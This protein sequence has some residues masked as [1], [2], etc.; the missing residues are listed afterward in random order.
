MVVCTLLAVQ[1]MGRWPFVPVHPAQDTTDSTVQERA[2]TP[3][4]L[5]SAP[6]PGASWEPAS[7]HCLSVLG[8]AG[9]GACTYNKHRASSPASAAGWGIG[10]N[11][12]FWMRQGLLW[13]IFYWTRCMVRIDKL[14][15]AMHLSSNLLV[16][17]GVCFFVFCL[18]FFGG[19]ETLYHFSRCLCKAKAFS[20]SRKK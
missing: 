11:S 16:C 20:E 3:I 18:L 19:R 13:E 7:L 8:G 6:G 2:Q 14:S 5:T 4:Y 1:P 15:N 10:L 17:I 9:W 12:C